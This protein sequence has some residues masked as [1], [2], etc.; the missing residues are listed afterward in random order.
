MTMAMTLEPI[1]PS[2]AS[3]AQLL[4]PEPARLMS[5]LAAMIYEDAQ[6]QWIAV[7]T[8]AVTDLVREGAN[9]GRQLE[10]IRLEFLEAIRG[11]V[12]QELADELTEGNYSRALVALRERNRPAGQKAR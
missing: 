12:R 7:T 4:P 2:P 10:C 1:P 6:A 5:E 11:Q 3:R 8:Q 9:I